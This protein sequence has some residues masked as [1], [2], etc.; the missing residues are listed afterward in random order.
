MRLLRFSAC[1]LVLITAL[2]AHATTLDAASAKA[3][4]DSIYSLYDHHGKGSQNSPRYLH[5]SLVK[6]LAEDLR[7]AGPDHVPDALK[8]DLICAC[9]QWQGVWVHSMG[10]SQ[11]LPNR[12]EVTVT[13]SLYAPEDR[14]QDDLRTLRY[15]LVREVREWRIW[16]IHYLSVPDMKQPTSSLR[17]QIQGEIDSY[18]KRPTP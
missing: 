5:S 6:L 11:P 15:V 9:R 4:L 18:G 3:L 8:A 7:A 17:V 1:V 16:N 12:V 14:P 13:F 2:P 10:S